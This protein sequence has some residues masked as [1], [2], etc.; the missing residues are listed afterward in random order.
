MST[1]K[2]TLPVGAVP[3]MGL[4]VSFI[5]PCEC[6]AVTSITI[7]NVAYNIVDAMG[8]AVTGK[9]D[10]WCSGALVSVLLD[11]VNHRAFLLNAAL[12]AHAHKADDIT[13]GTFHIARIPIISVAKG[14]TGSTNGA[15]GLKNLLAAGAT[16][17]S[18]YQYGNSLPAAGTKGRLFFKKVT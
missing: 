4:Q 13:R 5:A 2:V 6:N 1:I 3:V 12:I 7:D 17:L 15:T 11:T 16:V 18:S 10:V 9:S 14:G 8:N